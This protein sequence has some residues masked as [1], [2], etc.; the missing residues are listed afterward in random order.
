M[1][2]R[3][4]EGWFKKMNDDLLTSANYLCGSDSS[5]F[6]Y[7]CLMKIDLK[8]CLYEVCSYNVY[9]K[10]KDEPLEDIDVR[11]GI[12]IKRRVF[13]YSIH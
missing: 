5:L 11:D 1:E 4:I 9:L 13:F 10:L 2:N 6:Y 3:M 12:Y 8:H 7:I